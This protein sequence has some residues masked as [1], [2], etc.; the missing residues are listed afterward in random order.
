[1]R[2]I[3]KLFFLPR[4]SLSILTKRRVEQPFPPREQIFGIVRG[5]RYGRESVTAST[6]SGTRPS[7]KSGSSS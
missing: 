6:S 3:A 5:A 2:S 4:T 7:S 1:M